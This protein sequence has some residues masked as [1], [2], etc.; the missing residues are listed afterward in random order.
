M[1]KRLVVI[2]ACIRCP[3]MMDASLNSQ[4]SAICALTQNRLHS[5]V[6]VDDIPESCPLPKSEGQESQYE[7]CSRTGGTDA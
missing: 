1:S 3:F 6:I 5:N 7:P 2:G 4:H